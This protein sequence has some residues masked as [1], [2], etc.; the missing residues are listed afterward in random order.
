MLEVIPESAYKQRGVFI[1]FNLWSLL[2]VGMASLPLGVFSGAMVASHF[3]RTHNMNSTFVRC[4]R[5]GLSHYSKLWLFSWIDNW[6]TV[7]QILNR[8]PSEE[9]R[10]SLTRRLLDELVYLAWKVAT[11]GVI[12]AIM[13]GRSI[14]DS[15]KESLRLVLDR[16]KDALM[17]RVGYSFL[18]WI[19]GIAFAT[20]IIRIETKAAVFG[21]V[22]P[23]RDIGVIATITWF[24]LRLVK[25]I[26]AS[27]LERGKEKE[28]PPDSTTVDGKPTRLFPT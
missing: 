10:R 6:I 25:N 28:A 1:L 26:Q 19:V 21:A 22:G 2:I 13:N 17:L 7:N 9:D 20:D 23:L 15:G 4:L 11:I 24:L 16:P 18:C 8:V 27:I 3:L 14:V 5:L 12:P